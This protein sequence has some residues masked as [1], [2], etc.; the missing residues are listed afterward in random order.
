[1]LS[2]ASS[3]A[4]SEWWKCGRPCGALGPR[5]RGAVVNFGP[6]L[7]PRTLYPVAYVEIG[8]ELART[9]QLLNVPRPAA[10]VVILLRFNA[11]SAPV[12]ADRRWSHLE[13]QVLAVR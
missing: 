6:A 13:N 5:D 7:T 3:L 12:A 9:E 1:M 11:Q 4:S 2:S 10:E 8:Q